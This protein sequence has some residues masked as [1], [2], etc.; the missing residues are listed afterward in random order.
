MA[1]QAFQGHPRS[2]ALAPIESA[3]ATS[4]WSSIVN[5]VLSWPVSQILQ[6]FCW[7]KRPTRISPEFWGVPLGLDCR[8][9][10]SEERD[11]KLFIRVIYFK[12]VQAICSRYLNI[13]DGRTDKRTTY[14]SNT[15]RASIMCKNCCW[16]CAFCTDIIFPIPWSCQ[17]HTGFFMERITERRH[18]CDISRII[19]SKN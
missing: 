13:T 19:S 15:Y 16:F 3:Y 14:D 6:V 7:E 10:G 8:C 5:L 1:I 4:Y 9:C 12:L 18:H 11:P 2:S 17:C